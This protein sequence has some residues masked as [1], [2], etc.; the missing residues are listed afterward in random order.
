M[1]NDWE[2]GLCSEEAELVGLSTKCFLLS[3]S[4]YKNCFK[5]K[6]SAEMERALKYQTCHK[7]YQIE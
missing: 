4:G 2:D 6:N 3:H 7:K 5:K 1:G